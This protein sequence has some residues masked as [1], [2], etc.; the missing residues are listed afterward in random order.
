M[1]GK[2]LRAN[3]IRVKSTNLYVYEPDRDRTDIDFLDKEVPYQLG[4]RI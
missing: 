2:L 1:K 3:I 4:Y